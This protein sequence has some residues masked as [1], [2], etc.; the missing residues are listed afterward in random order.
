LCLK[1]APGWSITLYVETLD[2]GTINGFPGDVSKIST[3]CQSASQSRK[4][5]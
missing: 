3:K 1:T 5:T 4:F 2:E